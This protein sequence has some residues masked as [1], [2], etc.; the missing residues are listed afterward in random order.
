MVDFATIEQQALNLDHG[1]RGRLASAL[2]R[3]L[4]ETNEETM[5]REE[6]EK[7]WLIEVQ[8]RD[9]ECDEDPS[10]L[11]PFDDVMKKLR[12]KYGLV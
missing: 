11:I 12:E 2:I 9:K 6:I 1:L 3:S 8:R 10:V 5:S 4:D 7:L